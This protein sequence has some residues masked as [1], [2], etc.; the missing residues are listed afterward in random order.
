MARAAAS[1]A[2]AWP[3]LRSP[4]LRPAFLCGRAPRTSAC[5]AL[6][7]QRAFRPVDV[8]LD[9][10][11]YFE[12]LLGWLRAGQRLEFVRLIEAGDEVIV[13]YEV[14]KLDGSRGF[15]RLR[16]NSS[17]NAAGSAVLV[18]VLD[19]GQARAPAG[20]LKPDRST[21]LVV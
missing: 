19:V 1:G 10:R 13:T 7:G 14:N 6:R 11:G 20:V 15:E 17:G 3:R 12:R 9:R 2:S 18:S 4:R 8:G 16:Q 21:Q 5:V